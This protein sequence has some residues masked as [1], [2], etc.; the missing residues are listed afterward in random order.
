MT[1]C[2]NSAG[3]LMPVPTAVPPS[4]TSA[5]RGSADSTRSMPRRTCRAYPPNSCPRVT[6]VASI[7]WVRPDF[8]APAQSFAFFSSDTARW[9]SAGTRSLMRAPVTA[10]CTEVGNTSF[11]D[12]EAFTWSFGCT[13]R[14]ELRRCER[15]QHLVHVHVRAGA[16]PGLVGVDRELAVVVAGDELVGGDDDRVGDGSV[17]DAE[18]F[19]DDRG[20]PLDAGE[21]D[22]LR[23]LEP[24]SGDREVLDGA[25]RLRS[26]QRGRGDAHLAHGVVLD[27][28]VLA[29]GARAH[30]DV[31]LS[32]GDPSTV[33]RMTSGTTR[34]SLSR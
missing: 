27:A 28:E 21:G 6:G 17:D 7:R 29:G 16:R 22:D 4:G 25:L 5:T 23:G 2:E 11:D 12:C 30:D 3:M 14:A 33:P 20:G 31:C 9:S 34:P 24:G 13:G 19:V 32:V 8:T 15:G 26:V 18:L 10:T 1:F